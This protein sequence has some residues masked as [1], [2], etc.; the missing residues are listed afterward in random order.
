MSHGTKTLKRNSGTVYY[1]ICFLLVIVC[2]LLY[3]I[4][5]NRH[6]MTVYFTRCSQKPDIGSLQCYTVGWWG[7]SGILLLSSEKYLKITLKLA[8]QFPSVF[9]QFICILSVNFCRV[10]TV[11]TA[12]LTNYWCCSGAGSTCGANWSTR[13]WAQRTP[14]SGLCCPWSSHRW[15]HINCCSGVG[16]WMTHPLYCKQWTPHWNLFTS[17]GKR[18]G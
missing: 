5:D 4:Q 12:L 10:Y 11:D 18:S 8:R 17:T 2:V 14:T 3:I 13:T 16:H 9:F 1:S 7:Q 15:I 6:A